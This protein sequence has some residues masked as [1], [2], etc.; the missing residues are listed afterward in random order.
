MVLSSAAA[1]QVF[2][3]IWAGK[4]SQLAR[5]ATDRA[6]ERAAKS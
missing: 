3:E 1:Q 6:L 5:Q 2:K 4:E